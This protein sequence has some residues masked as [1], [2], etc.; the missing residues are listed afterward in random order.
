MERSVSVLWM[1][2]LICVIIFTN[3]YSP[4]TKS[5]GCFGEENLFENMTNKVVF[6]RLDCPLLCT[7]H[8]YQQWVERLDNLQ[9]PVISY[10][11]WY[12]CQLCFRWC[13]SVF[14]LRFTCIYSGKIV[15]CSLGTWSKCFDC[16]RLKKLERN[17]INKIR[18]FERKC[19][20]PISPRTLSEYLYHTDSYVLLVVLITSS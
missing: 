4:R 9:C 16:F 6:A 5:W 12:V 14:Q 15:I 19:S 13:C 3:S 11:K 2:A 8:L 20:I 17:V 18:S 1:S 10:Q 7:C